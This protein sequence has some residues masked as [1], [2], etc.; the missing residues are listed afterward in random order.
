MK[1]LALG[2]PHGILP[3]NLDSIIR[4]NKIEL[5]VCIGEVFPVKRDKAH[6]G[7]IDFNAGVAILDKLCSYKI[8]MII[9][10]GN[11]FFGG[12]GAKIFRDLLNKYK[13]KYP[14]LYY[15]RLGKLRFGG[16]TFIMLDIL[17]EKHSYPAFSKYFTDVLKHKKRLA[18]L[19][20]LLKENKDSILLSHAPPYGY[21]DKIH[22]GIHIG[23][24]ILLEAIKKNHPKL[25]LCGHVHE[26]KGTAKI[27]RTEIHNLGSCGNYKILDI[28]S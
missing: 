24:K 8:P 25:V 16:V 7:Q 23:S 21:L 28:T 20:K 15:K 12:Q 1:I 3:K 13:R 17:F 4:K 27:G 14:N 26:A 5:I 6:S 9:F 18:R 10:K 22:S 11:M 19:N 2:D